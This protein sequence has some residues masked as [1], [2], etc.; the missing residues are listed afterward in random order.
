VTLTTTPSV[1]FT[2]PPPSASESTFTLSSATVTTDTNVT[3]NIVLK[4]FDGSDYG[5][6]GG[7]LTLSSTPS[8]AIFGSVTD[9]G[10]G[11]YS[12]TVGSATAA[13]YTLTA[14]LGSVTLTT[15]PSVT[16][17]EPLPSASQSTFTL[18]SA[19]VAV[20]TNVNINIDLKNSDG[21]EYGLSSGALSLSSTPPGATFNAITDNGNGTYTATVGSASAASYTLTAEI[22]DVTLDTTPDITFTQVDAANT[23]VLPASLAVSVAG[24]PE[25]VTVTLR[26][27]DG[28]QVGHGGHT[29]SVASLFIDTLLIIPS[30]TITDNTDGTFTITASCTQM[31]GGADTVTVSVDSVEVGSFSLKCDS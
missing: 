27:A 2:Y 14:T 5:L 3:V 9:N 29:V 18:S 6:S 24:G 10:D 23:T 26:E 31:I 4:Q 21:S 30:P 19:A 20:G 8:G 1:I 13:S 15:T 28:S 17:S 16:F 25:T 12:A 22:G 7:T 11:T